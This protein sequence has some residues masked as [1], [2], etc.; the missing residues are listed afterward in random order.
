M[1]GALFAVELTGHFAAL[2]MTIAASAGAY[3]VSVLVMR[4]SILTEKIARRGRHIL[5]EY[6]VDPH[7]FL[8]AGQVMTRNPATL[9]GSLSITDAIDFFSTDASHRGYP[10]VDSDHRLLGLVSRSD[11]LRWKVE[12][13]PHEASL[14]DALSDASQPFAFVDRPIGQ[15]A[16][17]MVEAKTGRI[18]IVDPDTNRVVGILSRHDLLKVRHERTRSEFI[19]SSYAI[20]GGRISRKLL[21]SSPGSP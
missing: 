7:D 1:T 18:P 17:L 15:V 3:A 20:P 19:R 2:P 4:R 6:T 11:A 12:G 21:D 16:D 9:S 8:Q 5:Q 10:V 13:S 14:A